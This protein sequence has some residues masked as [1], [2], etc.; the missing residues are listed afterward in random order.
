[1]FDEVI[2]WK[3]SRLARNILDLLQIVNILE[4]NDVTFKSM[5]E[6]YDTST[7]TGKLMISM[8]ASIAEFERTTIIENLKMGM[9]ARAKKGLK[10]GGRMLGYKSVGSGKDSRLVIVP[11]EAEIVKKVFNMYISGKGY[12]A[13]ANRLNKEGYK[14]IKGNLFGITAISNI[15]SNPT[16]VGK[17]RF[18]RYVDYANKRRKGKNEDFILVEGQHEAIITEEVWEKAQEIRDT[19]AAKYP[20]TYSGEFPLTGLLVCPVCGH[21]MVAARTVNTL[22]GGEKRR[23]RYY[24]CGQ[25]RNKGSVACSANSVRADEAEKYVFDRIKEVLLNDRVLKDIVK[26]LNK[27]RKDKIKPLEREYVSIERQI[28]SYSIKK[29]RVFELYEDGTISKEML[30]ER[31]LNIEETLSNLA[32][33]KAEI[34][35]EIDKNGSDEIPFKTVKRTMEDFEKL[36]SGADKEQRKLFL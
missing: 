22:K 13:I 2:V 11:E 14:T 36:I 17:I 7:P 31:L 32:N 15:I 29:N 10:N 8:L 3:T 20:R 21:G 25:F 6:P 34:K 16:Y 27:N 24:S 1:M 4:K 5:T 18:N 26:K 28:E 35:L 12:K 23:I 30:N 33:R 19:R 9:V